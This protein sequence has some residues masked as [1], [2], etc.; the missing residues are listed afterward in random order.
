MRCHSQLRNFV[1]DWNREDSNCPPR[2]VITDFRVMLGRLVGIAGLTRRQVELSQ[3]H[4]QEIRL[5]TTLNCGFAGGISI[6]LNPCVLGFLRV[7]DSFEEELCDHVFICAVVNEQWP[8]N[9][10]QASTTGSLSFPPPRR[11]QPLR[12][13][14]LPCSLLCSLSSPPPLKCLDLF[15]YPWS[16]LSLTCG[17]QIQLLCSTLKL[18]AICYLIGNCH[19]ISKGKCRNPHRKPC[20][21]FCKTHCGRQCWKLYESLISKICFV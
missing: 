15:P 3:L 13:H 7:L 11:Q 8:V 20:V 1:V 9:P 5:N 18:Q 2:S 19:D 10:T 17:S 16:T 4:L 21:I 12:K 6:I 14:S